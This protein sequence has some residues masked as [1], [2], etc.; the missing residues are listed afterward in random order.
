[1]NN[2]TITTISSTIT[3]ISGGLAAANIF[4]QFFGVIA[5]ISHA[6]TGFY[7]NKSK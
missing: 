3:V 7:T 1:M 6:I 2:D 4:P 5:A